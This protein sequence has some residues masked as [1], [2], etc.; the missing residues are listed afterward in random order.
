MK[1]R[2]TAEFIVG[3]AE[4]EVTALGVRP[5]RLP[6]HVRARDAD[7][8]LLAAEAQPS[9]VRVALR[10]AS[11]QVSLELQASRVTYRGVHRPRGAV[12][13][14]VDGTH[15]HTCTLQHG[16]NTTMDLATGTGTST[17]G[18]TDT[19][20]VHGLPSGDKVIEFWLP[21]N[22]MVDLIHLTADRTVTPA[23]PPGRTWLHHGSS[24]S[25]GS[26]ATHPTGIWPVVAAR[27]AG[28]QLIN[29]GFSGSALIDPFMARVIR[30]T[31]ADLISLKLGINV[32]NLDAMRLRSFRPAVHG[33]LDT[34]REGHPTT[35][36]L[37]VSPIH[38]DIHEDTPGP[39]AFDTDKL[40]QGSVGFIATGSPE[41]TALGR[42]TLQ[43]IRQHLAAIVAERADDA[44][45]YL[46]GRELHGPED[47]R[48]HPLPDALHP[49]TQSHRIMGERFADIALADGAPL[50][51]AGR[52]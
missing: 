45:H 43:I 7:G 29:L 13:V 24:I 33:F 10:T 18:T 31:P 11:R 22:E 30:D 28:V 42:L 20:S 40:A 14:V 46:D 38:C 16:D 36:L 48:T 9:G 27:R 17:P 3:A 4:V 41:E 47:T 6:A 15:V 26:N 32:V 21:H 39:G 50:G 37:L 52:P 5:H 2:V 1:T 12:D 25:Q 44:L 19:I 49:G 23:H 51:P 8:Q 35:P 34:I